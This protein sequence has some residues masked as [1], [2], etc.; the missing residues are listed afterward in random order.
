MKIMSSVNTSSDMLSAPFVS[1]H[2][3]G[4]DRSDPIIHSLQ[5]LDQATHLIGFFSPSGLTVRI[6][7]V[8]YNK[9][10]EYG[11]KEKREK[12]HSQHD[13]DFKNT[14]RKHD[15]SSFPA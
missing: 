10:D 14:W 15:H 13:K 6:L 11:D 7:A 8:I 12:K 1:V 2:E 5:I 3:Y 9:E 4:F